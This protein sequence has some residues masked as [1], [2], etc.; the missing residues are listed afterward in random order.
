M[1]RVAIAAPKLGTFNKTGTGTASETINFWR[2]RR[3]S[4]PRDPFGSN[5]FQDRRIQP[6]C[7]SS[8]VILLHLWKPALHILL[9]IHP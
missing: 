9:H 7:H 1:E 5:G 4:N 6:L 8:A 2:R 3:D